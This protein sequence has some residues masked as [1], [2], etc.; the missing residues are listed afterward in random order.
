MSFS[1]VSLFSAFLIGLFHEE[2]L[3][4]SENSLQ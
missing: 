3:F 1:L 2:K 4:F